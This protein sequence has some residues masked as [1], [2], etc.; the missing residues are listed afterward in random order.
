MHEELGC[1][2]DDWQDL[3]VLYVTTDH[4]RDNLHL[5]Q[6]QIGDRQLD[7]DLTELAE[8]GWFRRDNLPPDVGRLVGKILARAAL[9][10]ES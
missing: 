2:I 10:S 3:G 8:A 4:H 9:A 6:A 1:R 5:F 7:I